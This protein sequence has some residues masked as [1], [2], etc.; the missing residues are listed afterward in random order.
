MLVYVFRN[1]TPTINF[2]LDRF[3]HF[4]SFSADNSMWNRL[5]LKTRIPKGFSL[6]LSNRIEPPLNAV[7]FTLRTYVFNEN[8]RAL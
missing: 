4:F 5:K 1:S 7:S 2:T 6:A 3:L 8:L